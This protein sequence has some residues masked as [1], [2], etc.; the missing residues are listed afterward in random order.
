MIV[1]KYF[2]LFYF[3][4]FI[5]LLFFVC[6]ELP[7]TLRYARG[8][9]TVCV[10]TTRKGDFHEFKSPETLQFEC[11]RALAHGAKCNIVYVI[12]G[13]EVGENL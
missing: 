11:F 4:T 1:Y 13:W 2:Y 3:I 6:S 5:Y 10:V 9:D 8:T 7:A 12:W